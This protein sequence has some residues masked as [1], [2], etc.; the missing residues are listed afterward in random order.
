MWSTR[1]R[2]QEGLALLLP[3]ILPG[4]NLKLQKVLQN[5][6][7]NRAKVCAKEYYIYRLLVAG[8]ISAHILI[9]LFEYLDSKLSYNKSVKYPFSSYIYF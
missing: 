1:P 6:T 4:Q 3:H 8:I 2:R 9:L 5:V 7:D